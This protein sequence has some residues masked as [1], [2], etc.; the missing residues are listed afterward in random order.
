MNYK[1]VIIVAIA[2]TAIGVTFLFPPWI[3]LKFP[4]SGQAN[5]LLT[6]SERRLF[7]NPP[8]T[9][10]VKAPYIAWRYP[11][12]EGVTTAVV[13]GVLCFFLRTKKARE[14]VVFNDRPSSAAAF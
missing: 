4:E 3:T 9:S 7:N 1:Q 2:A 14:S 6:H 11:V 8:A 5:L 13:A 10:D 12:Q